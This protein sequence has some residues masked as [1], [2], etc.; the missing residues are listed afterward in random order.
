MSLDP[1]ARTHTRTHT[2]THTHAH[3]HT[4]PPSRARAHTHTHTNTHTRTHTHTQT[5]THTHTHAHAHTHTIQEGSRTCGSS[6]SNKSS[7]GHRAKSSLS[8]NLRQHLGA[9]R[10]PAS[11]RFHW[12]RMM[13][14]GRRRGG[15]HSQVCGLSCMRSVFHRND[16]SL[17]RICL[18]P[19]RASRRGTRG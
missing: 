11:S 4:H 12:A 19:L 17:S 9:L 7:N 8:P 16:I 1:R 15:R 2:H 14:M 5:H 13:S 10:R 18:A 3:T 6:R